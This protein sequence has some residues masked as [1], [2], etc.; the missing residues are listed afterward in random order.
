VVLA[1]AFADPFIDI[2]FQPTAAVFCQWNWLG[3]LAISAQPTNV[4]D[5]NRS[6]FGDFFCFQ[7]THNVLH[8]FMLC[9]EVHIELS[10]LILRLL[11]LCF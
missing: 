4:G 6:A 7:Y 9:I 2:G 11:S 8:A 1:K 5:R 10:G 3:K